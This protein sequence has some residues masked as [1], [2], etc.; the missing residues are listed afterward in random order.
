MQRRQFLIA[1]GSL[2]LLGGCGFH[3]PGGSTIPV[4]LR[5]LRVEAS[6]PAGGQL[7]QAVERALERDGNVA[8]ADGPV[9]RLDNISLNQRA[10]SISPSTGAALEFLNTLR[11]SV[12][13]QRGKKIL[14]PAEPLLVEQSFTY[15]SGSPLATNEQQIESQQQLFA[16]AARV[17]LRRVL[18]APALR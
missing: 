8:R 11:G 3:L 12:W 7:A 17:V 1:L 16:E 2:S 15:N 18:L 13:V 5:G 4:R 6:G 14:L 10:I 9:L